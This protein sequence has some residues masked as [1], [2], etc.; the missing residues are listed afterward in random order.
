MNEHL[1]RNLPGAKIIIE[2]W[3]IDY[4][5]CRPHMNLG[6]LTTSAF[7]AR[8]RQDQNRLWL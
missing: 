1:F 5:T 8:S 6:G 3:R 2:A 7:A 4:N